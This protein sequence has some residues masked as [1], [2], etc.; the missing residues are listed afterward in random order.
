MLTSIVTLVVF[1]MEQRAQRKKARGSVPPMFV[2]NKWEQRMC[3]SK[4]HTARCLLQELSAKHAAN[5]SLKRTMH[6]KV[7]YHVKLRL[8]QIIIAWS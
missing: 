4:T 6:S 5:E 1:A 3:Q 8:V 7:C 2:Q